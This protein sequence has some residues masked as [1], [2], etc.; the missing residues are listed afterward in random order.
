MSWWNDYVGIPFVPK[1]RDRKGCDCW[2]LVRL[3]L[4]ERFRIE[5]PS[6]TD[7]YQDVADRITNSI[8]V[9]DTTQSWRRNWTE[10]REPSAGDVIMLRILG[11]PSH[12]GVVTK[13]GYMLHTEKGVNSLIERYDSPKWSSKIEGF[14]RHQK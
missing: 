11:I 9:G 8:L 14:W 13:P 6:L 7:D 5:V 4:L 1:G 12:V 10:T 3:V 2:G